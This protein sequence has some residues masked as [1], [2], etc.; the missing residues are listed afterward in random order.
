[1]KK[2][3]SLLVI[4]ML[5][6]ALAACGSKNNGGNNTDTGSN[7]GTNNGANNGGEKPS[8]K[9]GMVTDSG[10]IDDKS[11]NQG[12]WEGLER[13]TKELGVASKYL[14]PAGTTEADYMKEIGNLYDAGYKM[15]VVPGFKFETAI[16]A[17]Q[18]KYKDA[19]FVLIDG[20]PHTAEDPTPKVGTNTVSIFFAEHESGFLAGV[21]TAVQLKE[22][23]A[24]FI[25]GMEIPPVQK[26]NWGFQQGVKYANDNLGTKISMKKENV[27]YQGSFDNSAAGGQLAAQMYDRG[28]NVIFTA[29]GGVGVGAINEAKNRAKAGKTAWII[30]VDGDQYKD[31]VY[32][33]DK[34]V[35]LT[36][37]MKKVN[38]AS[39]DMVKALQE[40]KFPGGQTLTFDIKNDGVG[41]PSENPNL[42][43]DTMT[44]VNEAITKLKSGD[45]KVAAE[46]GDLIK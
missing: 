41:I 36:S 13:A 33:G 9:A 42:T 43:E 25:G 31:G 10:T 40:G 17:S 28:V 24:G 39:F 18:D 2:S 7:S 15:I 16:Y 46:K 14:K 26:Y 5:V 8:F 23:E 34:S 35:I 37:A 32:E 19:N 11:F 12:T 22:G 44:K 1:M 27:V 29:A 38:E 6:L 45:V 4:C 21:A 20:S 30:G 3:L